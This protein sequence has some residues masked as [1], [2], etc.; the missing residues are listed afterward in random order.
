MHQY[1]LGLDLLE[2]SLEVEDVGILV[3]NKL[4]MIH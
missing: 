3:D 4:T 1:R 2:N